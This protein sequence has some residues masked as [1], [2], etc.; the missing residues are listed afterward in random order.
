[1]ASCRHAVWEKYLAMVRGHVG[2]IVGLG[3]VIAVVWCLLSL[4]I[5]FYHLKPSD[6]EVR[7]KTSVY[8]C[9]QCNS[10]LHVVNWK[11]VAI[12]FVAI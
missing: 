7:E 3:V 6:S 9:I 4:P 12:N 2:E 11:I 1:M 8:S 5:I 10:K